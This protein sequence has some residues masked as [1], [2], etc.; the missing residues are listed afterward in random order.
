M[1]DIHEE[2][3][4][5]VHL[6][7]ALTHTAFDRFNTLLEDLRATAAQSYVLDLADVPFIDSSGIGMLLMGQEVAEQQACTLRL[8]AVG[9]AVRAML[10]QAHVIE[11]FAVDATPPGLPHGQSTSA[12]A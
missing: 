11:L 6:S 7:G 3:T 4:A 9:P 8:R 10:E 2:G 12:A 5:V 1:N